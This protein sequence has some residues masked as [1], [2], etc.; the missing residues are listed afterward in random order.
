MALLECSTG[1]RLQVPLERL[2][3]GAG[4]KCTVPTQFPG[5]KLRRVRRFPCV[6][7][8]EACSS[9]LRLTR[10]RSA[11]LRLRFE[12]RKRSTL[13][14]RMRKVRLRQGVGETPRHSFRIPKASAGGG[15]G[16]IRTRT[17]R[18]KSPLCQLLHHS[19]VKKIGARA[20][21]RTRDCGLADRRVA[22]TP[23]AHI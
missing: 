11:R 8:G 2:S 19:S 13:I 21:S 1:T 14:F 4:F 7:V 22:P 5:P 15:A 9:D 3:F 23:R 16:G 6:V 10:N 17:G 20:G 18:I 12:E